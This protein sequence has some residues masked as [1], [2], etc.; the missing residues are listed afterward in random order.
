M[1][2]LMLRYSAGF[3]RSSARKAIRAVIHDKGE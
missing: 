1:N 3:E 2:I